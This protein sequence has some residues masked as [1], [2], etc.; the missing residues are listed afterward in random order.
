[1]VISAGQR[2]DNQFYD[3]LLSSVRLAGAVGRPRCKPDALAGDNA[4]SAKRIR[5]DC[6]RRGITPVI[7]ENKMQ[8]GY[9][10]RKP[11]RKPV[12]DRDQY[13]RRNIVERLIGWL[14]RNRRVATRYE[15]LPESYRAFVLLAIIRNLLRAF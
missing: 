10:A 13:R 1:M 14:K 7:P 3:E 6:H 4:Y 11:G 5:H 9:R 8:K 2:H 12:L 15:K